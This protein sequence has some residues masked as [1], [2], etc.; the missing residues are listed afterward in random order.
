MQL[1]ICGRLKILTAIFAALISNTVS[2][3]MDFLGELMTVLVL[4]FLSGAVYSLPDV[5]CG[6]RREYIA[7]GGLGSVFLA[8]SFAESGSIVIFD[9][10]D[11]NI[12]RRRHAA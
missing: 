7:N 10:L 5:P 3:K 9:H 11:D 4:T 2:F 6:Y 1:Y 12:L 8:A